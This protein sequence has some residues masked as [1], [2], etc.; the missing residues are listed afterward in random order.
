MRNRDS[1]FSF[2]PL[3]SL[4]FLTPAL[5]AQD[6]APSLTASNAAPTATAASVPASPGTVAA[7][8]SDASPAPAAADNTPHA[9]VDPFF[10]PVPPGKV[11][12][13]KVKKEKPPKTIHMEIEHG[14]LTVDGWTG[15][16]NLNFDIDDF[17][18]FYMW[19]PGVGTVIV[20][21]HPFPG[22][23]IQYSAFDK[24]TLTV[25]LDDHQLQLTADHRIL[26]GKPK[27][28]QAPAYVA[29]DPA[30][31]PTSSKFPV[32]GYGLT[33]K[34]PYA[35]PGSLVDLRASKDAPPLPT[36]VQP[37]IQTT[38]VCPPGLTAA[39]GLSACK[40]VPV[41]MVTGKGKKQ[42]KQTSM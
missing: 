41:P 10:K 39:S 36:E 33:N 21:N 35:W 22:A 30:F 9:A 38:T 2:L 6:Q 17:Q 16:A 15:K 1:Y 25:K 29:V 13:L 34:A 26:P 31:S 19:A 3:A 40:S 23:K 37:T 27:E 42:E 18:Y 14:V 12:G 11:K 32:F 28:P 5:A 8:P 4:L 7:G 20:S 24:N